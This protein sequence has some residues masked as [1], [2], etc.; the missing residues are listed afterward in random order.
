[1]KRPA[2]LISLT[3]VLVVA[4]FGLGL[5]AFAYSGAVNVAA[6]ADYLPGAK[7]FFATVS[8]NS[9][10]AHAEEAAKRGE[11]SQPAE[12]TDAMLDEILA[13]IA[14]YP[15]SLLAQ[16]FMASTYPMEVVEAARWSKENPNLQG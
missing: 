7:W 12:V 16:I 2:V 3:V 5:V 10:K 4:F 15:D 14:L 11:I 1:M 9:I 13:P 8:D 6:S